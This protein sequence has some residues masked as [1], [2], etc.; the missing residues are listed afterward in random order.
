MVTHCCILLNISIGDH[1]II[2]LY[3]YIFNLV[4]LTADWNAAVV[5]PVF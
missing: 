3:L 5:H 1:A 4:L 2:Y